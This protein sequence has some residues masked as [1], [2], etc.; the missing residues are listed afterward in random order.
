[1][2][3][4]GWESAKV[5]LEEKPS[6]VYLVV[7]NITFLFSNFLLSSDTI[8]IRS[9]LHI[10]HILLVLLM[11]LMACRTM[12]HWISVLVPYLLKYC[13]AKSNNIVLF[14]IYMLKSILMPSVPIFH[15]T[16]RRT[17]VNFVLITII[18]LFFKTITNYFTY[19]ITY[20]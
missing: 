20:V 1:M 5:L 2:K 11:L 14:F 8:A 16:P 6:V 13:Q 15:M 9:M 19:Y 18:M 4:E 7:W 10:W 17:D 12:L 3:N